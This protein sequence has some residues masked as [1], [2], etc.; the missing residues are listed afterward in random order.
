MPLEYSQR[1]VE[2]GVKRAQEM[3]SL[4]RLLAAEGRLAEQ[5]GRFPD[6]VRSYLDA[7]RLGQE[8]CRGGLVIDRTLGNVLEGSYGIAPLAALRSRLEPAT[9]RELIGELES[10]DERREPFDDVAAREHTLQDA[11]IA[12]MGFSGMRNRG[13]LKK[14]AQPAEAQAGQRYVG[15][16]TD[17]RLL[18]I[19]LAI[20]CHV[21]ERGSPPERLDELVPRYFA[22]VPADPQ[23]SRSFQYQRD[24]SGFYVLGP[25]QAAREASQT[26]SP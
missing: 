2:V 17:L 25:D 15:V 3:R 7:I 18:V 21:A 22:A 14:L 26:N 1:Q 16:Q 8:M 20:Q 5:E 23:T 19:E 24:P 10:L 4:G 9:C 12:Q 6:A 13:T 11:L